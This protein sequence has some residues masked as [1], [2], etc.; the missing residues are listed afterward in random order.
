MH[1]FNLLSNRL[2]QVV[3]SLTEQSKKV[4]QSNKVQQI[5][6]AMLVTMIF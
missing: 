2:L 6:E 5:L 4:G 3:V 1:N